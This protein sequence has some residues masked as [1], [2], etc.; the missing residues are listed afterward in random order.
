MKYNKLH[1]TSLSE[2]RE[3]S[4]LH[5]KSKE[6]EAAEL[7]AGAHSWAALADKEVNPE[8]QLYVQRGLRV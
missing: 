7:Q 2:L 1:L 8:L 4:R 3:T 6:K 5:P